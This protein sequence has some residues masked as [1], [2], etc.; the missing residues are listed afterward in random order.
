[1]L[2]AARGAADEPAQARPEAALA[3]PKLEGATLNLANGDHA[4]GKLIDGPEGT[5]LGWQ[6]EGFVGPFR[7]PLQFVQGIHFPQP[8]QPLKPTGEYC[9]ELSGGDVLFGSLVALD[10]AQAVLDCVG[11]GTL[12]VERSRLCRI[13]RDSAAAAGVP[14]RAGLVEWRA[15]GKA[16]SS[17]NNGA[18]LVCSTA[19]RGARARLQPPGPSADRNR[20]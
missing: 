17:R 7:F 19:R 2:P 20:T 4:R 9:F 18:Q 5:S 16:E 6:A 12:H 13:V 14:D 3:T 1:M 15:L 11:F 8:A 10:E